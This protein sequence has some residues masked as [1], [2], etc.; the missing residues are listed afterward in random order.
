LFSP[1][2]RGLSVVG[3][4]K[5]GG[6]LQFSYFYE[7]LGQHETLGEAFRGW[8]ESLSPYSS[9]DVSY[10]F[11]MT[12]LG[13]PMVRPC[14]HHPATVSISP[15]SGTINQNGFTTYTAVYSDANGYSNLWMGRLLVN[16][17][18]SSNGGAYFIYSQN[19][20]RL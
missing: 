13:D 17:S 2:G 11:G 9:T 19:T 20:N 8:F 12:I 1:D 5:S 14:C 16:T 3:S 7:P 15:S 10:F 18:V 6:M 4:T